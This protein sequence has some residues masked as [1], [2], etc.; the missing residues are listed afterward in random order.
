[1]LREAADTANNNMLIL[2]TITTISGSNWLKKI[3]EVKKFGLEEVCLFPTCLDKEK[4]EKLYALLSETGLKSIPFVHL[5]SDMELQELAYLVDR[6]QTRVFNIHTQKEFALLNDYGSYKKL[7]CLEN[8]YK[9]FDE[10]EV[11]EFGGI[12]L[13]IS[14][15]EN[16]RLLRPEVY[17]ANIRTLKKYP[18]K[19]SHISVIKKETIIDEESQVR[20]TTHYMDDLSELDYLKRYP[21]EFFGH[22]SAIEL[23]NTIEEQL[24]A[25][26]YIYTIIKNQ[27][28]R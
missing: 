21:L 9:P 11:Q 2:P 10:E 1:M 13:D 18:P 28:G 24:R 5:R 3:A 19:C 15:L 12:C 25:K 16:D 7:I 4:R 14:H 20:I 27:G 23:E 17:Q 6:Y 22:V 8:T 26:E